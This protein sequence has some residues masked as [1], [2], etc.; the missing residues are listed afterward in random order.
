[1]KRG[2]VAREGMMFFRMLFRVHI[3]ENFFFYLLLLFVFTWNYFLLPNTIPYYVFHLLEPLG[4]N[5]F[6]LLMLAN[7]L[8]VILL[9]LLFIYPNKLTVQAF[10]FEREKDKK[11]MFWICQTVSLVIV[12]F[13]RQL[14]ES[15][16]ML[17]S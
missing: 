14:Y 6:L 5:Q 4:I 3:V 9:S 10:N 17:F 12:I 11:A 8:F 1:M 2:E 15:V 13:I 7:L 16:I